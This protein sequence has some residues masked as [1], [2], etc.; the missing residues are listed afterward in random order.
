MSILYM[1]WYRI[2]ISHYICSHS[3]SVSHRIGKK[4]GG[5]VDLH[6]LL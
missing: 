6:V 1:C 5:G 4:G 2:E 3:N